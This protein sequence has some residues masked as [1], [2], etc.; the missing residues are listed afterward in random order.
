MEQFNVHHQKSHSNLN[1]IKLN[2]TQPEINAQK[3]DF[4]KIDKVRLTKNK[5]NF[6]KG[7]L[8]DWIIK[9]FAIS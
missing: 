9:I 3:F 1:T 8:P 5:H 2:T 7:Y 6:N 4:K